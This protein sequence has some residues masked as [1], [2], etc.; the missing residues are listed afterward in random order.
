MQVHNQ[1]LNEMVSVRPEKFPL[2]DTKANKGEM[3]SFAHMLKNSISK[4]NQLLQASDAA[5]R[6]LAQGQIEI[7]DLHQVVLAGE[8][9]ELSLLLTVQVRNKIIEG[10]QELMRMQV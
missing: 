2:P 5:N 10:Y 9:A 8:K 7:E 4:T 6:N 3:P 1:L